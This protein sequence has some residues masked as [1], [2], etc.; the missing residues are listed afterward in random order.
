MWTIHSDK[1]WKYYGEKAPYFG[2]FGQETYLNKNLNEQVMDDFFSSGQ[3]HVENL[4]NTIYQ[5]IDDSF[6]AEKILD[7][8]CGPGRLLIPFASF[9]SEVV[10]LDVSEHMIKE[11]KENCDRFNITNAVFFVSDDTL[12][13][14]KNMEFDLVNSYIVLQHLNPKRGEIIIKKLLKAIK[15]NGVG[16]LQLTYSDHYPVRPL[17]NFFR[18]RI[19]FLASAIRVLRCMLKGKKYQYLP[20]MQ[21]NS[22]N[23]NR[24]LRLLQ[25]ENIQE[26]YTYFTNHFNYGGITIIFKKP[27]N[28]IP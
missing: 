8:G 7:F 13:C 28:L 10:G 23:L 12:D 1:A 17:L 19:P 21:M 22:Y 27:E 9:A 18:N 25:D 24:I 14:I 5:K 11:A 6:R 20:Q 16:V 15:T 3:R 2:V 4:F 26:F